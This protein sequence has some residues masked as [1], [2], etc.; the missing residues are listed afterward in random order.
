MKEIKVVAEGIFHVMSEPGDMTRY[1]YFVYYDGH[2]DFCFMPKISTFRFPQRLDSFDAA[3]I[4]SDY[5][6]LLNLAT[7]EN[8]NLHTLKECVDTILKIK[9]GL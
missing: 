4:N 5:E 6:K 8:C 3:I 2:N 1:D 7:I 9:G